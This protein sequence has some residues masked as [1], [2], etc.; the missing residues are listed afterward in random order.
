MH[1]TPL[2]DRPTCLLGLVLLVLLLLADLLLGPARALQLRC[3][4]CALCCMSHRGRCVADPER[5]AR[6]SVSARLLSRLC[7]LLFC[8]QST[9]EGRRMQTG[10]LA[11]FSRAS[12][13]AFC[14]SCCARFLSLSFLPFFICFSKASRAASISASIRAAASSCTQ[15]TA[16]RLLRAPLSTRDIH[17]VASSNCAAAHIARGLRQVAWGRARD[18]LHRSPSLNGCAPQPI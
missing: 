10:V 5:C 2:A 18:L 1:R 7:P 9:R 12:R 15:R 16:T 8:L 13:S 4:R 6:C 3:L 14:R 11:H 17:C